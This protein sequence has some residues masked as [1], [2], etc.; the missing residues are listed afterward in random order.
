ML[1]HS[2]LACALRSNSGWS[3]EV[4]VAS[5]WGAFSGR[6]RRVGLLK[7]LEAGRESINLPEVQ[8]RSPLPHY[9]S[10]HHHGQSQQPACSPRRH[11][12]PLL[13]PPAP[14]K[15]RLSLRAPCRTVAKPV[16]GVSSCTPSHSRRRSGRSGSASSGSRTSSQRARQCL[17]GRASASASSGWTATRQVSQPSH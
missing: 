16:S 15:N 9:P 6:A 1:Y 7:N 13:T 4:A 8:A 14:L 3:C 10:Y 2:C 12:R 11:P 5:A 17:R